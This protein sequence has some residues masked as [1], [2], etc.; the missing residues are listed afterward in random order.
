MTQKIIQL[1]ENNK[2]KKQVIN[3]CDG[4]Y[5]TNQPVNYKM[6]RQSLYDVK[7]IVETM[8]GYVTTL[9]QLLFFSAD[10]DYAIKYL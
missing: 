4:M 1:L 5:F 3:T 7:D 8:R 10:L 2:R 6:C 9:I